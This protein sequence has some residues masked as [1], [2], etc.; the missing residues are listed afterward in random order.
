M[1]VVVVLLFALPWMLY[2]ALVLLNS[3]MAQPFLDPWVLLFCRTD[4]YTNSA[5]SPIIYSLTSQKFHVAF[6]TKGLHRVT[7]CLPTS[8]NNAVHGTLVKDADQE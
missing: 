5:I 8:S 1:L 6:R 7:A 2:H 3:F 4:V